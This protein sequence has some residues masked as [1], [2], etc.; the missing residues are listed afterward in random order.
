MLNCNLF[1]TKLYII[2]SISV[3]RAQSAMYGCNLE[4]NIF[5]LVLNIQDNL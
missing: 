4:I 3:D 5:M 1:A 2:Y